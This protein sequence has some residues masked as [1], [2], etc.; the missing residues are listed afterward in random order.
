MIINIITSVDIYAYFE[1]LGPPRCKNNW[2]CEKNS[3]RAGGID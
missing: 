2:K 3:Y 1:G